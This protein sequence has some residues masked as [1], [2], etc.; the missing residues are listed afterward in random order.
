MAP[1]VIADITV[2]VII[3]AIEPVKFITFVEEYMMREFVAVINPPITAPA[4]APDE[5]VLIFAQRPKIMA[6]KR[7]RVTWPRII[8]NQSI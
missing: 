5:N 2:A 1:A 4:I 3:L 7:P 6:S 8:G